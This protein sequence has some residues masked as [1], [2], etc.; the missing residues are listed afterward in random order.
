MNASN[1]GCSLGVAFCLAIAALHG[2]GFGRFTQAMK[3][4]D[5]PAYLKQMFPVLYAMPSLY[6]VV[7]AAFGALAFL[8]PSSRRPICFILTLAVTACG[9]LALMLGEWVPLLTM[10]L[11]GL[12]FLV[13]GLMATRAGDGGEHGP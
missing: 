1:I 11:G 12:A 4:S 5:A 6:L 9:A 3:G 10:G 13:A 2:S 7:L 8:R